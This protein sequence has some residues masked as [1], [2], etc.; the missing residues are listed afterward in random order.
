M[1]SYNAGLNA[2]A[3]S[4]SGAPQEALDFLN[5]L[6]DLAQLGLEDVD[7]DDDE[8]AGEE[9]GTEAAATAEV[10][11]KAI[12][13]IHLCHTRMCYKLDVLERC[14]RNRKVLVD[15][16][17]DES[18]IRSLVESART[19]AQFWRSLSAMPRTSSCGLIS[20]S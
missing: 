9:D 16:V 19:A 7:D 2:A 6:S 1:K 11:A 10:A 20:R 3:E 12:N 15:L 8:K 5:I 17:Y 14:D 13:F 4:S 18:K